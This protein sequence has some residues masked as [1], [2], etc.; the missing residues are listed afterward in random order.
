MRET[1]IQ[2]RNFHILCVQTFC[3]DM[4][5]FHRFVLAMQLSA[6]LRTLWFQI[7]PL[8][9]SLRYILSRKCLF[10]YRLSVCHHILWF[11]FCFDFEIIFSLNIVHDV[12]FSIDPFISFE[13]H[14]TFFLI[15]KWIFNLDFCRNDRFDRITQWKKINA[16]VS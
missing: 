7:T 11:K 4:Y 14:L 3:V 5:A 1:P 16:H 6:F 8:S 2:V 10:S 13:L 9:I 12:F 15:S